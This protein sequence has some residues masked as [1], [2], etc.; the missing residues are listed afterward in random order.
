MTLAEAR[1]RVTELKAVI[2]RNDRLYYVEAQ[3]EISDFEYDQLFLELKGI[4]EQFP[5][6]ADDDSPTRRVGGAPLEGLAP[7]RHQ[8]PMLSLDNTYSID[9]LRAWYERV[10]RQLGQPPHGLSV[11]LKIDGVS[12]SMHYREGRLVSAATR[13][14]GEVGDDV[15][16]NARTIRS[17]PLVL[18]N[19]PADLEVRGEV[20]MPRSTFAQVNRERKS[21]GEPE[22]ANPRNAT[23][24]AIRLLDSKQTAQRRLALWCYQLVVAEGA[25]GSS[26]VDDLISLGR[27]GF[28]VCPGFARCETIDQVERKI[29]RWA[30]ERPQ[31][32]Y[33]TDGVVIK[34]DSRAE[35]N[36]LGATARAVRWAVAF[37]YPP[38]GRATVVNDI[39]VQIGRTGVLTPV[40]DLKPVRVGGSVVSRATLHNF[41]EVERLDVRVGDRVVVA[42]GGDV[43]PKIV[44][45]V[46]ADRPEGTE[47]VSAPRRCPVCGTEV[48]GGDEVVAIRCPNPTCPA[49]VESQLRHFVSRGAMEIEGLGLRSMQQ[50][51]AEGHIQ[52]AASLWD[53][54]ETTLA[55]L[56]KWGEVSAGNLLN[57][58]RE[59]R[60]RSLNRLLFGL[61]VPLVGEG[62]ARS[63]AERFGS[64]HA[65]ASADVADLEAV[66]GVGPKMAASVGDWFAEPRNRLF[67]DRLIERGVDPRME[68]SDDEADLPLDGKTIVITGTLSRSRREI[69]Q[70]L[71]ALGA[72][73]SG[74][75]SSRTALV[76]AG[77]DAGSKLDKA[78]KLGVEILDEDELSALMRSLKEDA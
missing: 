20:F 16:V 63:L 14:D 58:L 38:E 11:E 73:V 36:I 57:E 34:V 66:D 48:V 22:F 49:V 2:R 54:D 65:L 62:A 50:L 47:A 72:K 24:G 77:Q 71:E 59:A 44:G 7:F 21:A 55:L 13:G 76:V 41:D 39:V 37:K 69:K 6:L 46:L 12:L 28:P 26:H 45:V 4:E 51:V 33:D 15:T 70:E 56:P 1:S 27:W 5:D 75:V 19:G 78:Q 9:E 18:E 3:P 42:K 64:L 32:D 68:G 8:V 25:Q 52:D 30:Q 40:A 67:V 23:A 29:A 74:S 61:G 10:C 60:G 31:L 35:R 43:I 17:L 53:L